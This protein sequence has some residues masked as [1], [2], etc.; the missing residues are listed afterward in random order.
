MVEADAELDLAVAGHVGVRR[1][2]RALLGEEGREHAL[3]VLGGEAHAVQ[4]DAQLLAA[5][6]ASWKSCAAVQ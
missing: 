4:R 3:A 6:R 1:A 5:A 2:A